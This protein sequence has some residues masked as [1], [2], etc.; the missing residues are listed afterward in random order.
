M[1]DRQK[2]FSKPY[3]EYQA[4]TC[5]ASRKCALNNLHRFALSAT[6]R[7]LREHFL[8]KKDGE[9]GR[10]IEASPTKIAI[11]DM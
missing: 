7:R 4:L 11:N 9:F 6:V 10:K 5:A 2:D 8:E 3:G 1:V